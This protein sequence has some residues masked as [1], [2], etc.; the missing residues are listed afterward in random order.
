MPMSSG[1]AEADMLITS[2]FSPNVIILYLKIRIK[3]M[4]T[5]GLVNV[6]PNAYHLKLQMNELGKT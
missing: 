4:N 6:E 1:G 2:V 5:V 3:A